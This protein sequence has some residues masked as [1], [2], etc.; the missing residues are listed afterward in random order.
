MGPTDPDEAAPETLRARWGESMK[1]NAI[2][3]SDCLE[4]AE[5]ET[6]FFFNELELA[7]RAR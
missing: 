1:R 5:E 3:G 4:S 7:G 6:T 2:H